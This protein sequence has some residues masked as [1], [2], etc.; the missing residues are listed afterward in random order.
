MRPVLP[1]EVGPAHDA[2]PEAALGSLRVHDQGEEESGQEEV[3]E[4]H[5]GELSGKSVGSVWGSPLRLSE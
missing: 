5:Q 4:L 1:P 2:R 3:V